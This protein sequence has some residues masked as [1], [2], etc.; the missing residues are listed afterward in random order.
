MVHNIGAVERAL[1]IMVGVLQVLLV[2]VGPQTLW[3]LVGL[4]PLVTG[5]CGYCPLYRVL[6]I[7]TAEAPLARVPSGGPVR[8]LSRPPPRT[9][10]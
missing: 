9:G 6:G 5:V 8:H 7:S 2:L 10:R 4:G 3:A 1:R